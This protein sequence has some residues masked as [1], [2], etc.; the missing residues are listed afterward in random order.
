MSA[1]LVWGYEAISIK[2]QPLHEG[3]RRSHGLSIRPL[4]TRAAYKN[5]WTVMCG[6]ARGLARSGVQSDEVVNLHERTRCQDSRWELTLAQ[7]ESVACFRWRRD[8]GCVVE[9]KIRSSTTK[10]RCQTTLASGK[11]GE[12]SV[13]RGRASSREW[14]WKTSC[15]KNMHGTDLTL[16]W[17][18]GILL[19]SQNM[20]TGSKVR[21][22][23]VGWKST[24]TRWKRLYHIDFWY[25]TVSALQEI[26]VSISSPLGSDR[27]PPLHR[28]GA[29]H[30]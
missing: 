2:V 22:N 19:A 17:H 4:Q 25:S 12:V 7:G 21:C 20:L 5:A 10:E 9:G 6:R 23:P 27:H 24:L 13:D 16:E 14:K 8:P 1:K 3:T 11:S 29:H 18:V 28:F 15:S 26:N 30:T